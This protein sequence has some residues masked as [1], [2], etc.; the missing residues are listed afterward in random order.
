MIFRTPSLIALMTLAWCCSPLHSASAGQDAVAELES[1]LGGIDSLSADVEQLLIEAGG[2]VLEQSLIV[3]HARKPGGFSWEMLEPFVELIVTDG[4]TLWNYQPELEQVVIE[5]WKPDQAE[6]AMSLFQ[7][8]FDSLAAEY[9]VT[10]AV[11]ANRQRFELAPRQ[12][13]SPYGVVTIEF[14]DGIVDAIRIEHRDGQRTAWLFTNVQTNIPLA[15]EQFEFAPP[16]GIEIVD[17]RAASR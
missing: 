2:G 15:D 5:D 9:R 8:E 16:P 4:T 10:M 11:A 17:S 3:M 13:G 6:L 12:L 7:G 1:L 14:L